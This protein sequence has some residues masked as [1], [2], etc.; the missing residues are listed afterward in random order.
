MI[1][2]AKGNIVRFVAVSFGYTKVAPKDLGA[3]AVIDSFKDLPEAIKNL[4]A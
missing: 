4:P 1:V 2:I 3:D